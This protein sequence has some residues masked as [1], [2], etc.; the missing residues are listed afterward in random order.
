MVL[1]EISGFN[2]QGILILLKLWRRNAALHR[3][4]HLAH[5]ALIKPNALRAPFWNDL[6]NGVLLVHANSIGRAY[7]IT[8]PAI[9]AIFGNIQTHE[10]TIKRIPL[11]VNERT[12]MNQPLTIPLN[13]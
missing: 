12:I 10:P 13:N 6:A 8:R 1:K 9:Y 11:H 4:L 3:T 5:G 2:K 7:F